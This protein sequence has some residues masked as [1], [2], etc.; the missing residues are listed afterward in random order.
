MVAVE[1]VPPVPEMANFQ[2]RGDGGEGSTLVRTV[3]IAGNRGGRVRAPFCPSLLLV[4]GVA[5]RVAGV[6]PLLAEK[7]LP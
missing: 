4:R 6:S 3:V 1:L 2:Q 5:A 7:P